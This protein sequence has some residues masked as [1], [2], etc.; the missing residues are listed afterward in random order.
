ML[1]DAAA[2]LR[3]DPKWEV[4]EE[5]DAERVFMT[6]EVGSLRETPHVRGFDS[7]EEARTEDFDVD[8]TIVELRS[9]VCTS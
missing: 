3:F 6:C 1:E 4:E 9:L 5:R 7:K 8:G 2:E